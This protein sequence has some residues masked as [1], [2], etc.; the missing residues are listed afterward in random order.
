[1]DGHDLKYSGDVSAV[2]I[3]MSENPTA[4]GFGMNSLHSIYNKGTD[5]LTFVKSINDTLVSLDSQ[6][7]T[8][9][10][11]HEIIKRWPKD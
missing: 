5:H 1:M 10:E 9:Q 11:A 8:I 7:D 6:I 2:L 3:Q 4:R